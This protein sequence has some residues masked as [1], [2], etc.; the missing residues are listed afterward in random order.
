VS[1]PSAIPVRLRLLGSPAF[2]DAAGQRFVLPARAAILILFI[3]TETRDFSLPRGRLASFLWPDAAK[4]SANLRQLLT[5]L[6]T[7]QKKAGIDFIRFDRSSVSLNLAGAAVD[8]LEM[9]ESLRALDWNN[10]RSAIDNYGGELLSGIAVAEN[11]LSDWLEMHRARVRESFLTEFSALVESPEARGNPRTAQEMAAK[12]LAIDSC[13]EAAYRALMRACSTFGAIDHVERIFDNCRNALARGMGTEPS[14]ATEAL[15]HR[16]RSE[17]GPFHVAIS[18]PIATEPLAA[19]PPGPMLRAVL[20]RLVILP[21]PPDGRDIATIDIA[22]LVLDDVVTRLGNLR[23]AQVVA[24][25]TSWALAGRFDDRIAIQF[26]IRYALET[27]LRRIDGRDLLAVR[28][29]DTHTRNILWADTYPLG[30]SDLA[31][32]HRALSNA[33]TSSLADAIE[34]N[35]VRRFE[36]DENPQAYYWYLMGQK[37]LRYMDLPSV[38]RAR[39]AFRTAVAA[40]PTFAAAHSGNARATQRQWLVL[41]RGGSELL[42]EAEQIGAHAI[43]LDHRDPRGYRELGL[44]NLYRRHWDDSVAFFTEAERLGPQHADLI[45]DFGDALGHAGEP[46]KGLVKVQRAMELNPIPPDQYWWNAAGL[47]FQLHNYEA[48]IEAVAK[49][50]DPLPA[51]RIA[52]AAWAYLGNHQEAQ[53][54]AEKFL[55]SYPDFRIDHWLTIVPDRNVDDLRHYE[56]GLKMAGFR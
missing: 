32:S 8:Y 39:K 6:K 50:G 35:E 31:I 12:I 43:R 9:Q 4:A 26:T 14:P 51:L 38:R 19:S 44:S 11:D 1:Q 24:W 40:D 2:V 36:R 48:A 45:S 10:W 54:C 49:M 20:P 52:A 7:A 22:S 53:R 41:G 21:P 25:H 18:A 3:L 23:T 30:A 16:L 42:D 33:V 17:T 27:A 55:Q 56:V 47:H 34:Y 5:R 28:L 13:Q 15:Y 37:A 29:F 46:A